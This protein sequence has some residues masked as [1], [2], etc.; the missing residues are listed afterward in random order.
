GAGCAVAHIA[1]ESLH[2]ALVVRQV[3][4]AFGLRLSPAGLWRYAVAIGVMLVAI[5]LA[6]SLGVVATV[7]IA[8]AAYAAALW[9]SG[10]TR[11]ADHR[12]VKRLLVEHA[13]SGHE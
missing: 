10:Y 2:R 5:A 3:R 1:C 13:H 8:A 4:V 11:S 12:L 7:A 9:A 6:H